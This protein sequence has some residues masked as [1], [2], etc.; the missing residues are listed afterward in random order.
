MVLV[1]AVVLVIPQLYLASIVRRAHEKA[2]GLTL[3]DYRDLAKSDAK[4]AQKVDY[5]G[6]ITTITERPRFWVYS[7]EELVRWCTAQLVAV[8]AL[9]FQ[10]TS[11]K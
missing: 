3:Q 4:A 2:C 7:I 9:Y 5:L 11:L 8:A 1:A 6:N 10:F